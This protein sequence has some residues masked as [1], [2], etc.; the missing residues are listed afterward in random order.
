MKKTKIITGVL[1]LAVVAVVIIACTKEK[2]TKVA[3]NG[4]EMATIS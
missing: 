1:A 3:Q 4:I 2:E